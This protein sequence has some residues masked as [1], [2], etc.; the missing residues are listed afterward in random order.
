[1]PQAGDVVLVD[2]VGAT[3]VKR[4]PAVVVSTDTYHAHRPDAL[5]VNGHR[6][7][8]PDAPRGTAQHFPRVPAGRRS[9]QDFDL[10]VGSRPV[11]R[12]VAR[13]A[14][15][16]RP[17]QP[18]VGSRADHARIIEDKHIRRLEKFGQVAKS[19]IDLPQFR[20]PA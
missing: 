14:R 12:P 6:V 11:A 19:G 1:M 4:R 3:G 2:F 7:A 8:R 16:A 9:E 15:P 13:P 10:A 5:D 18:S 17:F 20:V